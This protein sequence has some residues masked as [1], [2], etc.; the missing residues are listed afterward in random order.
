MNDLLASRTHQTWQNSTWF[1]EQFRY[2]YAT[3]I[4][5]LSSQVSVVVCLLPA[6]PESVSSTT[7]HKLSR[8]DIQ[9]S[10]A[11]QWLHLNGSLCCLAFMLASAP[12]LNSN[13]LSLGCFLF[14]LEKEMNKDDLLAMN[15]V[16][17]CSDCNVNWSEDWQEIQH[18]LDFLLNM[19]DHQLLFWYHVNTIID[20]HD[21]MSHQIRDSL[22]CSQM[23][24]QSSSSY[25]T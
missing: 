8:T 4:P 9:F 23:L 20:R 11:S 16:P 22:I 21:D 17:V 13:S 19:L 18:G 14:F 2:N 3:S 24:E 5:L 12:S 1:I 6:S 7:F 15:H 10:R 25:C